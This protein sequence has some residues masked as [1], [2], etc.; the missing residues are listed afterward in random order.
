MEPPQLGFYGIL[1]N[2]EK[3]KVVFDTGNLLK[4]NPSCDLLITMFCCILINSHLTEL[5]HLYLARILHP[6]STL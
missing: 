3:P 4:L 5:I 2:W 1:H 6:R